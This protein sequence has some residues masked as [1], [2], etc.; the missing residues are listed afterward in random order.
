MTYRI[1]S[2]CTGVGALDLAVEAVLA[3]ELERSL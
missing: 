2:L 1:G 3:A